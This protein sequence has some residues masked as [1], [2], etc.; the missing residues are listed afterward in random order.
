VQKYRILLISILISGCGGEG[1]S[2]G[3]ITNNISVQST[4][5]PAPGTLVQ[6]PDNQTNPSLPSYLPGGTF[7]MTVQFPGSN[8]GAKHREISS[9]ALP[10]N[11][12]S[13]RVTITGKAIITP[14]LHL[15]FV[16]VF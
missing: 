4:P 15:L 9:S 1:D 12:H 7:N 10:Y 3:A 8:S 14:L 2:S 16:S 6:V 11:S 13:L 5:T